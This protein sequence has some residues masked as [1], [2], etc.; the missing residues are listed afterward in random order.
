M[1]DE[2]GEPS[3]RDKTAEELAKLTTDKARG[4]KVKLDMQIAALLANRVS[5]E[6]ISKRLGVLLQ[7]VDSV[8]EMMR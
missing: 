2:R 7:H 1:A 5:R 6:S 8:I 3:D 4:K